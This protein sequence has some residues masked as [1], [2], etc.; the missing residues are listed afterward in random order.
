MGVTRDR[1]SS[2]YSAISGG[3]RRRPHIDAREYSAEPLEPRRL[4][5]V[6]SWDGGGDNFRWMDPLNWS[7]DALPTAE[8]DVVL[9][10]PGTSLP[11]L[12]APP[13]LFE[14]FVV[15]SVTCE[16]RLTVGGTL[17]IAT[18]G[19][20][21]GV[22]D[23]QNGILRG[24]TWDVTGGVLQCT[25]GRENRL[26]A[27]HVTGVVKLI[28][29]QLSGLS[30]DPGATFDQLE[31]RSGSLG[32]APG[33]TVHGIIT[34]PGGQIGVTSPGTL[35]FAPDIEFRA[36][37]TGKFN[38]TIGTSPL[39]FNAMTL[40]TLAE[41]TIGNQQRLTV[42]AQNWTNGGTLR[43]TTGGQLFL[44]G[45][46]T[47]Q[48]AI[49]VAGGEL[50]LNGT[51]TMPAGA[52]G[53]HRV[54]GSVHLRGTLDN[55]GN[56]FTFDKRT[57]SW[58]C[59]G[60]VYGTGTTAGITGG[61]VYFNDGFA[62]E[63][64]DLRDVN[65]H[66]TL[67]GQFLVSGTTRFTEARLGGELKLLG[68]YV[69]RDPVFLD[70]AGG[71]IVPQG[72][73]TIAS[74]VTVS[75]TNQGGIGSY[76]PTALA[77]IN[78]GTIR[79]NQVSATASAALNCV[80][81]NRGQLVLE[82]GGLQVY[83]RTLS[84]Q[85]SVQ[86]ASQTW[87]QFTAPTVHGLASHIDGDGELRFAGGAHNFASQ[88]QGFQGT[89][90]LNGPSSNNNLM[91]TFTQPVPA[92]QLIVGYGTVE[93]Q[94]P[95]ALDFPVSIE[96]GTLRGAAQLEFAGGLAWE[97]GTLEGP[98]V[99]VVPVGAALDL[100]G[101]GTRTLRTTLA[102]DGTAEATS[103][104]VLFEGSGRIEN[105][106][107]AVFTAGDTTFAGTLGAGQAF[108]NLGT[109]S[110]SS[111]WLRFNGVELNNSGSV[112]LIAGNLSLGGGGTTNTVLTVPSP[113]VLELTR[114]YAYQGMGGIAGPSFVQFAGGTHSFSAG[115]LATTGSVSAT[116]GAVLNLAAGAGA[117]AFAPT[118]L[119]LSTNGAANLDANL[120]LARVTIRDGGALGGAGVVTITDRLE[121]T[122]G[123]MRGAGTTVLAPGA[124]AQV[125]LG[126]AMA[127]ARI[128]D[129]R[130][131]LTIGGGPITFGDAANVGVIL[132]R[133]GA[134]L[135]LAGAGMQL[136]AQAPGAHR[137]ENDGTLRRP[138]TSGALTLTGVALINRGALEVVNG[139]VLL[140]GGGSQSSTASVA[141]PA[142]RKVSFSGNWSHALGSSI[143][144]AGT[145]AFSGGI[146]EVA[147]TVSTAGTV[148]LSS[149]ADVRLA[150]DANLVARAGS[151]TITQASRL[152]LADN[153]MIIDYPSGGPSPLGTP[154]T[155]GSIFALISSGYA[156]GAW[157]GSGITSSAAAADPRLAIG[158]GES[159]SLF[160]SFPATFLGQ[161]V[162]DSAVLMRTTLA[163]DANLDG[164]VNLRDF[165]RLAANF[166]ASPRPFALGDFNYDGTVEIEDFN[167]LASSFG[168]ALGPDG[169]VTG[170]GGRLPFAPHG[171]S[172][173]GQGPRNR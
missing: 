116:G 173:I 50:Q 47:N 26:V 89:L 44:G 103:C 167:I 136:I 28:A 119:T 54:G 71:L 102:N 104:T 127:L 115:A 65:L 42:T 130:T 153:A 158:F 105:R 48:G 162:D 60:G 112:N 87:I 6:V 155:T 52:A 33:M 163:G 129:N 95:Q 98:G 168:Q 35:T 92:A 131:S 88:L 94:S 110:V 15:R 148:E 51:F 43:V 144:G 20:L 37:S 29:D 22:M 14:P 12:F 160:T 39:F 86:L 77:L 114:S 69:L 13:N 113:R 58:T 172:L 157:N 31:L 67:S 99:L 30:I 117:E 64:G 16:E 147:A 151:L 124:T 100:T 49:D 91:V 36:D 10:V 156:G 83:E 61:D 106:A 109:L 62:L 125:Q 146:H 68:P 80:L 135:D 81:E 164:A 72:T 17:E 34:C 150:T 63:A 4:L 53:W 2:S 118:T 41:F 108:E 59:S 123:R 128:F 96:G 85:G 171:T 70:N 170:T 3:W 134:T 107:G 137:I 159:G 55:T 19:T 7:S 154:T 121:W 90:R 132:N 21:T 23:L 169:M 78:E 84:N 161:S 138:T 97:W 133:A 140:N 57:G 25:T 126:T 152:D 56:T 73:V 111:V 32:F 166:G 46:W 1:F 9:A 74:D 11:V 122:G 145:V 165:N 24:G 40:N 139:T 18:T 45:N 76:H 38:C 101:T 82:R 93:F 120:A 79:V 142:G 8:D 66:G 5:A 141:V 27:T 143:G 149:G 75:I